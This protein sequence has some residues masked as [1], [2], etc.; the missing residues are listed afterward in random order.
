MCHIQASH[1]GPPFLHAIRTQLGDIQA[2]VF[3][4]NYWMTVKFDFVCL[5]NDSQEI[6]VF[7]A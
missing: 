3:Y 1:S 2:Q 4:L 6:T 5:K 7:S